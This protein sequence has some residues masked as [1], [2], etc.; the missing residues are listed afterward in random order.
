MKILPRV[1]VSLKVLVV[2]VIVV[3]GVSVA[4]TAVVAPAAQAQSP[5]F[6]YAPHYWEKDAATGRARRSNYNQLAPLAMQ[7]VHG[8]QIP[9]VRNMIGIDPAQ[10]RKQAPAE[11]GHQV[12]M[13]RVVQNPGVF[14]KPN[15]PAV[16]VHNSAGHALPMTATPILATVSGKKANAYVPHQLPSTTRVQSYKPGVGFVS[17]STA[18][19]LYGSEHKTSTSVGGKVLSRHNP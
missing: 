11:T 16:A 4:F 13:S 14:G 10:L 12:V 3:V 1:F 15:K 6:E 2:V 18:A 9:N 7:K 19:A 17:G 8:G 5:R